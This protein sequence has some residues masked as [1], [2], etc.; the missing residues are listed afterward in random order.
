MGAVDK[1]NYKTAIFERIQKH[2]FTHHAI[3]SVQYVKQLL[4]THNP[5]RLNLEHSWFITILSWVTTIVNPITLSSTTSLNYQVTE[6]QLKTLQ[7]QVTPDFY[8]NH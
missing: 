5:V 7:N 1:Y 4:N 2:H 8:Y 3:K 6:S